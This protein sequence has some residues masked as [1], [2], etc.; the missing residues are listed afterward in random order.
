MNR[1]LSLILVALLTVATP[2]LAQ[3]SDPAETPPS[4]AHPS[5]AVAGFDI[6]DCQGCHAAE[7]FTNFQ[8]SQHARKLPRVCAECHGDVA[9][10]A[11][12]MAEGEGPGPIISFKSAVSCSA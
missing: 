5:P 8:H 3:T 1:S 2:G 11:K 6:N 10:H 7:V 4:P 12:M 9:T